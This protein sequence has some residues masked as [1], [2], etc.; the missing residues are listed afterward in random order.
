MGAVMAECTWTGRHLSESWAEADNW[1]PRPPTED[2]DD[3]VIPLVPFGQGYQAPLVPAGTQVRRLE[4]SGVELIGRLGVREQVIWNSGGLTDGLALGPAAV[5]MITGSA[6]DVPPKRLAGLLE[7][8]SAQLV[9]ARIHLGGGA[10]IVNRGQLDCDGESLLT[11]NWGLAPFFENRGTLRI[12]SGALRLNRTLLRCRGDVRISGG[13]MLSLEGMAMPHLLAGQTVIRGAGRLRVGDGADLFV[14]RTVLVAAGATLE[15]AE[16]TLLSQEVGNRTFPGIGQQGL[17]VD[18]TLLWTAGIIAG[19]VTVNQRGVLITQGAALR[20]TSFDA[21]T[22]RIRGG[23]DLV[24][25]QYAFDTGQLINEGETVL[26]GG[27]QHIWPHRGFKLDN[28]GLVRVEGPGQVDW[29]NNPIDNRGVIAVQSG[30]LHLHHVYS[31]YTQRGTGSLRVASEAELRSDR[32]LDL[33]AGI[34][35]GTGRVAADVASRGH[36]IPGAPGSP[37][38]LTIDGNVTL[39]DPARLQI[40]VDGTAPGTDHGQLAVTGSASLDSRLEVDALTYAPNA[41]DALDIVTCAPDTTIA[42]RFDRAVLPAPIDGSFFRVDYQGNAARLVA[43]QI[44]VGF[45]ASHYPGDVIM[46]QL[47]A[48]GPYRWTGYYLVAPCHSDAG[49]VDR[50]A[51]LEQIGWKI[52]ILYVGQ[53]G[54]GGRLTVAQGELDAWDATLKTHVEGF[55]PGSWIYLD[56][57]WTPLDSDRREAL[58]T[59]AEAWTAEVLRLGRYSPALY[60]PVQDVPY[61][62]PRLNRAFAAAGR[63]DR[64]RLWVAAESRPF[65]PRLPPAAS[66]IPEATAWQQQMDVVERRPD[67]T[68]WLRVGTTP[69]GDPIYWETDRNVSVLADPSGP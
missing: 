19:H 67:G 11:W 51:T 54:D 8:R 47:F 42:G 20:G 59:Y 44:T 55:L 34:L 2:D 64:P 5:V 37:G 3:D 45:D 25:G 62:S 29:A 61:L 30:T 6:P 41:G 16:G 38:R 24:A 17:V 57:E 33:A 40:Q 66:T 63:A 60:C 4:M 52:A 39:A 58:F 26:H 10:R 12:N 9:G 69:S 1:T 49:W 65:D 35:E 28:R 27:S 13:A 23:A 31:R 7:L 43:S 32:S 36:M 56:V 68:P 21:P 14:E 15:L 46:Q 22:I 50:R 18:G 48:Q 53:Q